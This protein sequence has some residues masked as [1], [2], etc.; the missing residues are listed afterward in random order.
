M[1]STALTAT[2]QPNLDVNYIGMDVHSDNVVVCVRRNTI[3]SSGQLVGKTIKTKKVV[4]KSSQEPLVELLSKYADGQQHIMTAE[5]TFN[6]YW[7]AD[8]AEDHGWNFRLADPCT[9]SQANIKAANDETDAEYL[10]DRLRT[11]SL[12]STSVLPRQLRGVR[13]LM[14]HRLR[15]MQE[16]SDKKVRLS[17][18]YS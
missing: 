11:G 5:S 4:I 17:N 10:A 15:V 8:I 12:K 7:L 18:L 9:V 14:R 6:W 16:V 1:N 13:D 2:V 3:N